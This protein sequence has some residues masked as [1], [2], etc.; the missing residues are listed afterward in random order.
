MVKI[1]H[2]HRVQNLASDFQ[3]TK[4]SLQFNSYLQFI[5]IANNIALY[6]YFY[7]KMLTAFVLSKYI[8]EIIKKMILKFDTKKL[9][10]F[11]N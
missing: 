11:T 1:L 6:S 4:H 7:G 10:K 5:K 2:F 9:E 8:A 3:L